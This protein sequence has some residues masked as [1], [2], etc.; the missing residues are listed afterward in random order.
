MSGERRAGSA[1]P[2][3]AVILWTALFACRPMPPRPAIVLVSIDTLRADHLPAYG[4]AAGRTPAIDRLRSDGVLYRRAWSHSPLTLPSHVSVFSG[5]LPTVHGV[6]DNGGF[7]VEPNAPSLATL[8]SAAGYDTAAFVSAGVLSRGSGAERGFAHYD[9]PSA[10]GQGTLDE[11]PADTTVDRAI[12]WLDRRSP[13]SDR[14]PFLFVHLYEPHAPYRPPEPYRSAFVDRPYDGEIAT[15]DAAVGRLLDALRSRG[16]YDTATVLLFSDHGEGLGDHGEA[17]HGV[18]LYREALEVPMIIKW[19]RGE[20]AGGTVEEPAQLLDLAPTVLHAAGL[21]VPAAMTGVDLGRLRGLEASRSIYAETFYPRLHYGWSEMTS[22]VEGD[23][24]YLQG[25]F[26]ELF[27]LR[28]D[29][30]ERRS[31]VDSERRVAGEMKQR[32]RAVEAPLTRR[33]A[34]DVETARRLTALGYLAG[35]ALGESAPGADPRHRLSV[36][37]ELDRVKHDIAQGHWHEAEASLASLV[38]VDERAIDLWLLLGLCR[39]RLQRFGATPSPASTLAAFERALELSGGAP[40]YALYVARQLFRM[41]R[42]ADARHLLDAVLLVEPEQPEALEMSA[43]IALLDRRWDDAWRA[44]RSAGRVSQAFRADLRRG[45]LEA[46]RP[47]DADRAD[48]E[49]APLVVERPR[50][51]N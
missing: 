40:S 49:L 21:G 35:G 44:A 20:R 13:T 1:L 37:V 33:A 6:R 17:G 29:P 41:Q 2:F 42:L 46:G 3:F 39:E 8:L 47:R 16:L 36:L 7:P 45:L 12:E 51:L 32:L 38:A 48:A 34:V 31:L 28:A 30:A 22:L 18:L 26:G 27:D 5:V 14:P 4:Y 24:H 11:R 15:A 10:E 50:T 19:P 23:R 9:D 43:A 25:A